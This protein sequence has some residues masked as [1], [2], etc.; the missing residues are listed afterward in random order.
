MNKLLLLF[1]S[2]ISLQT[3]MCQSVYP[4]HPSVGDTI[5][6]Q[7]KLDYSLFADVDN[8]TF[9]YATIKFENN[10][11]ILEVNGKDND[12]LLGEIEIVTTG[13]LSQEEIIEEQKK[14]QKINAYYKYLMERKEYAD[15]ETKKTVEPPAI[16]LQ[17]PLQERMKKEARM[18]IRLKEDQIRANEFQ[19]GLRPSTR[20]EFSR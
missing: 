11:F 3:A 18:M 7:E 9:Q 10:G 16:N 20:I 13:K 14:I 4:L 5:E 12:P 1:F 19:F 15:N 6:L 17:G 2:I 8:N